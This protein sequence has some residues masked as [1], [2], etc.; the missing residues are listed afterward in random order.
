MRSHGFG[1]PRR[2]ASRPCGRRCIGQ[3]SSG[4]IGWPATVRADA[5]DFLIPEFWRI[6]GLTGTLN[7]S[8]RYLIGALARP[9]GLLDQMRE[10]VG[11]YLMGNDN[12]LHGDE[13]KTRYAI[14][15]LRK[16]KSR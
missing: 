14:E 3:D 6:T 2:F 16:H 7:P 15:I 13:I 4:G 11:P 8:D 9:P 5:I 12:G 1:T 10:I